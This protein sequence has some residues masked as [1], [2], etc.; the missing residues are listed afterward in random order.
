MLEKKSNVKNLKWGGYE[1]R[2]FAALINAGI[3]PAQ[4]ILNLAT[5]DG[6]T[7][8]VLV[9]MA[10]DLN[11]GMEISVAFAKTQLIT[12]QEQQLIHIAAFS[13]KLAP[14]LKCIA[15][16]LE[17]RQKRIKKCQHQLWLPVAL[18]IITLMVEMVFHV[19]TGNNNLFLALIRCVGILA[20][21]LMLL[22]LTL[23]W[24][25]LDSVHWL[26]LGWRM[27]FQYRLPL[28]QKFFEQYFYTIFVWQIESGVDFQ[29]S[30]RQMEK[31]LKSG[32]YEAAAKN[33]QR[34]LKQGENVVD[35]LSRSGVIL[36]D[37]LQQV[38][39]TGEQSGRLVEILRHHLQLQYREL[40]LI[41]DSFYAWIPRIYYIFIVG[42]S[43]SRLNF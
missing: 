15:D 8:K 18:M 35:A 41:T 24:L 23:Y 13:G 20:G 7:S 28:F 5:A 40:E 4:A 3:A 14:T 26:S 32:G 17:V 21:V 43:L 34:L 22:R 1:F 6:E 9:R 37:V 2:Q 11:S 31:L 27:G 38:M 30:V 36:T 29:N 10:K 42:L 16:T 39:N 12:R 25:Q 33:C 19:V